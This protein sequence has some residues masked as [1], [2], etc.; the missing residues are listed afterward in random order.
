MSSAITTT[1]TIPKSQTKEYIDN[2][3][4]N[5]YQKNHAKLLQ[6]SKKPRMC[7]VCNRKY[8]TSNWSKHISSEKHNRNAEIYILKN[9]VPVIEEE[10]SDSD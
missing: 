9:G 5:Y 8:Q 7:E 2:Y 4:K 10:F 3:N 6:Y 1:P